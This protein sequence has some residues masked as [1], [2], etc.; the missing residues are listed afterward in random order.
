MI[1]SGE[2]WVPEISVLASDDLTAIQR[3]KY[4]LAIV[5]WLLDIYGNDLVIGYDIGCTFS[6]TPRHSTQLS[7]KVLAKNIQMVVPSFYNHTH[8]WG[9][10][11]SWHPMYISGIGLEDFETCEHLFSISNSLARDTRHASTFHHYQAIEEF[12]YFWDE[13][14]YVCKSWYV[15]HSCSWTWD[16]WCITLSQFFVQ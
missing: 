12:F 6:Q 13:D 4:A 1:Q 15:F 3:G 14:K 7:E 11:L 9:C 2:L 5:N 16:G 10:Q 8:N